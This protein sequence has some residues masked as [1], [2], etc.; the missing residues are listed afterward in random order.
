MPPVVLAIL[1]ANSVVFGAWLAL[2]DSPIMTNSFLVSWDALAAGRYWTLLGSAFSH[3]LFLHFFL[4]MY[5]L[6]SFGSVVEQIIGSAR[7]LAFYLV[8]AIV[9]SFGHAA[10]SAFLLGQPGLPALGASG[11]VSG[12]I[13]LFSLMIPRAR[14]LLLGI[15]PMPAIVGAVLFVGLDIAGL[16]A[17]TGGG[18]LP[19]G[20]GAHLSGAAVGAL[21]YLLLAR[22][23][24]RARADQAV[25]SD[26]ESW[27]ALLRR[28][29]FSERL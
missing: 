6:A 3:M 17:Q 13:I 26:L 29:R 4:N 2:G 12:V 1:I 10:V 15:F 24:Q 27:R 20:H 8:A 23:L 18:G 16:A 9:A 22:Q 19:I 5:V 28:A 21:T 7:F 11:A 14:I 25:F